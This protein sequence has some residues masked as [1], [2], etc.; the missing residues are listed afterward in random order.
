MSLEAKSFPHIR[1]LR[2]HSQ[3]KSFPHG[4][5]AFHGGE[6]YALS[7]TGLH[8][9]VVFENIPPVFERPRFQLLLP[10]IISPVPFN[11]PRNP[12]ANG[13]LRAKSEM[14]G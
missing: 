2:C 14:E 10:R 7:D 8:S 5:A 1:L 3:G 9:R 6:L 13:R 12:L 11:K 4:G